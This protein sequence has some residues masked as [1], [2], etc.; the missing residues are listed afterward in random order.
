MRA[1]ILDWSSSRRV[2]A[3]ILAI[4]LLLRAA[5]CIHQPVAGVVDGDAPEYL[6]YAKSIAEGKWDAYP[7]RYDF[8][9]PPLYP[10]FLA[11]FY[12]LFPGPGEVKPSIGEFSYRWILIRV[13]QGVQVLLG[14]WTCVCYMRL[15]ARGWNP[16]AGMVALILSVFHPML[17][18]LSAPLMSEGLFMALSAQALVSLQA[19]GH[20]EG[21][22]FRR[23]LASGC[24][25]G[26]ACLCRPVLQLFL[27][28]AAFWVGWMALRRCG[29]GAALG[30]MLVLTLAV[31]VWLVP[32][33]V[34]NKVHHGEASLAPRYGQVCLSMG[35][36]PLYL[37][38]Y[39]APTAPEFYTAL[40]LLFYEYHPGQLSRDRW[41]RVPVEFWRERPLDFVVLQFHKVFHFLCPW[42]NPLI[43]PPW[44]VLAT[45]VFVTPVF[46]F[47]LHGLVCHGPQPEVRPLFVGLLAAGFVTGV[48]FIT[49]V[50][51]RTTFVDGPLVVPASWSVVWWCTRGRRVSREGG[52]VGDGAQRDRDGGIAGGRDDGAS[53]R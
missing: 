38:A 2:R 52:R 17:V 12:A 46:G 10:V 44:L 16:V 3:M 47:G 50:R 8:L 37:R 19:Y 14:G 4:G 20:A 13:I 27:P 43:F 6:A 5:F 35:N 45:A 39:L 41:M 11:G 31:S 29:R 40:A 51:Y 49:A 23:L 33:L 25:L 26:L 32:F 22:G 9:R 7:A 24:W 53:G 1:S 36:H 34:W 18:P 15:A 48:V 21:R 30:A 42:V 28:V